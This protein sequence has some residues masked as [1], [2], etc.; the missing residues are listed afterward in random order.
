MSYHDLWPHQEAAMSATSQAAK[1]GRTSGLL[2]MPTG[3]GKT[4]TFTTIARRWN[5][6]T[7]VIVHRDEL[8]VQATTSF[9][10]TWPEV[11]VTTFPD[12][13]WEDAFVNVL[14][15][16]GIQKKLDQFP[17]DRYGLV[18]VD[19]A[20]HARAGT[21]EKVIRHFRPGFLLGCTATPERLDG[22]PL[23]PLF[24][25]V[26]YSYSLRQAIEE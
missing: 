13:G 8:R 19:E 1:S 4:R 18:V 14:T 23:T 26:L 5:M 6:P 10:E 25:D 24:G 2:V 9:E 21:W 20:H 17:R 12:E 15:V 7:L 11:R 22:K 16:Q 3:T